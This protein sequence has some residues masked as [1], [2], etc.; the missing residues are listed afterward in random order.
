MLSR[1]QSGAALL[2]PVFL[3]VVL[4]PA[5]ATD[6]AQ[7]SLGDSLA[8]LRARHGPMLPVL[9]ASDFRHP[10]ERQIVK[11]LMEENPGI[12]DLVDQVKKDQ[13]KQVVEKDRFY[14]LNAVQVGPNQYPS[15]H[16]VAKR[17]AATL[18]LGASYKLF[19][20][21]DPQMQT[22]VFGFVRHDHYGNSFSDFTIRLNSGLVKALTEQELAFAIGREMGHVKANHRFYSGLMW[23]YQSKSNKLPRLYPEDKPEKA[24]GMN[25]ALRLLFERA[26]EPSRISE[27]TA[28]RAGLVACGDPNAAYSAL[29]KLASGDLEGTGKVD[30]EEFLKQART[31]GAAIDAAR[32]QEVLGQQ[33][34]QPYTITR[35]RELSDFADSGDYQVAS[36]RIADPFQSGLAA[37]HEL[38]SELADFR[39]RLE[40]FDK[41]PKNARLESLVRE[42]LKGSLEKLV[43]ARVAPAGELEELLAVHV[44]T[45]GLT[46]PNAPFD[47][48]AG[49]VRRK[50]DGR[51]LAGLLA[52]LG[53]KLA[54]YI[55]RPD[56]TPEARTLAEARLATVK[57]LSALA[58]AAGR[59]SRRTAGW[60][61]PVD[62]AAAL[63]KPLVRLK[64]EAESGDKE[65]FFG[66]V[67]D[68]RPLLRETFISL[69]GQLGADH[70]AGLIEYAAPIR[71]EAALAA[72][73]VR[74]AG[75]D[76]AKLGE[77]FDSY[78]EKYSGFL[79]RIPFFIVKRY[80]K[81]MDIPVPAR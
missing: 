53:E 2:L 26:P 47:A 24:P 25:G 65:S 20:L 19:I 72:E 48:L 32:L 9:D 7:P 59:K 23:A 6:A 27:F 16:A 28:D 52:K 45:T 79:K 39:S 60:A 5:Y 46:S 22:D 55:A 21:N 1:I 30:I 62:L 38:S 31:T 37:F 78:F 49:F 43:T 34:F 51:P 18:G 67:S 42:S 77:L 76:A 13:V 81:N 41:D 68:L 36:G 17:A 70:A 69:V 15:V 63:S 58:P 44:I 33:G 4:S 56:L 40:A 75:K 57:Q 35:V 11:T 61:E 3:S 80:L 10:A 73:Q 54:Y 12:R 66:T 50:G 29:A 64:E 14:M 8:A 74:G 71:G